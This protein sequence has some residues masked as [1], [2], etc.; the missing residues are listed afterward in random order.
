MPSRSSQSGSVRT[1]SSFSAVLGFSSKSM[2]RPVAVDPHDPA[3]PGLGLGDRQGG[4]G[5]LGL[6]LEV[7]ADHVLE[8][9]PVE[10]VAGEDQDEVVASS[11]VK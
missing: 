3:R 8:V 10:L 11:S 7:G 2:T 1:R 9:H 4:D 6:V 5:D